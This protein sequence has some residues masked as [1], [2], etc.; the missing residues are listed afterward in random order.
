MNVQISYMDMPHGPEPAAASV[1]RPEDRSASQPDQARLPPSWPSPAFAS[2]ALASSAAADVSS[3]WP[4]SAPGS[5]DELAWPPAPSSSWGQVLSFLFVLLNSASA[6]AETA[7][8][9]DADV[10]PAGI[11]A[12]W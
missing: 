12:C 3:A 2:E 5:T 1:R 10:T 11:F 7:H 4:A 8:G 9:F 6:A